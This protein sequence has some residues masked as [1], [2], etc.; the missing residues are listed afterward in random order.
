MRVRAQNLH[1]G[2]SLISWS[3]AKCHTEARADSFEAAGATALLDVQHVAGG[4]RG[5]CG[6]CSG[7]VARQ[8][9]DGI[10]CRAML[11]AGLP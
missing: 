2:S 10:P 11:N 5:S 9:L 3:G 7:E 8:S 6:S 4:K 1:I